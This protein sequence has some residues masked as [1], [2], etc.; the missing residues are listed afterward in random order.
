MTRTVGGTASEL[1]SVRT[2]LL[3]LAFGLVIPVAVE[4]MHVGHLY[5]VGWSEGP[6]VKATR[7][8]VRD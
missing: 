4:R 7:V 2:C 3:H 8:G 5:A 6:R 1:T